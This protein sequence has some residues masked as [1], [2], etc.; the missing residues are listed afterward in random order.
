MSQLLCEQVVGRGLRRASYEV[1]EDGKFGE[2]V[3][4]VFGVPFEVIPFKATKGVAPPP[5][6]KRHHIHALPARAELEIRFPRVEGYTQAVRNRVSVDWPSVATLTL[7]PGR[8]PPEVEV[9][10]LSVSNRGRLSLSG[11]GR[12]SEVTLA[13]FR[14]KRRLQELVFDLAS[15]LTRTYVESGHCE[16]PAHVL[17]P[18]L[19]AI[20]RQYVETR[21]IVEP[22]ADR[23]DLFLAPYYG[24][25]VE[26]LAEAIRPDTSQGET[27]EIPRYEA[28]RGLGT[29]AD[30]D[31]WTSRD[32]REV[33]R[34]HLNYVVAD[35]KRWEQS[36][37]YVL[38]T[39]KVVDAFV[40]NAGLGFA[41]P[42]L[43]NGQMHDYVP[44]FIVRTSTNGETPR[45]LI[46]E[47]KGFD[48]LEGVKKAAAERWIAAVNA[49][50][51][52]GVWTYALAKSVADVV[53][54][55]EELKRR[56]SAVG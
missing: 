3:A 43:N 21:V 42:Y 17:F 12:A 1:R 2:E 44:D 10:G 54:L 49:D 27:P 18:Q 29:T 31:F 41:I 8:I 51:R 9:K 5:R 7:Q 25:L 47:T 19:A 24:W 16:A 22:P 28:I 35:T 32:V 36:T 23:K 15:D 55:M 6:V 20:V 56:R 39:S 38:D 46:L 13:S 26:R 53:V 45:H 14:A 48:P 33:N 34:S 52:H 40:K 4:V 37:A 11:P 50:G 30:V